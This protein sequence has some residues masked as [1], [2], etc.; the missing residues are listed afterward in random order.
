MPTPATTPPRSPRAREPAGGFAARALHWADGCGRRRQVRGARRLRAPGGA[1]ALHATRSCTSCWARPRSPTALAE[2]WGPDAAPGGD[3][4]RDRVGP[5]RLRPA[6]RSCGWLESVLH[7]LVGERIGRVARGAARRLARWPWSRCRC[8]SRPGWRAPS[9]RPS[10]SP[11]AD[12]VRV[13]RAGARGTEQ[14]DGRSA[15]Q[16]SQ[17]E[18]AARATHV[19]RQ[20]TAPRRAARGGASR[21][22]IADA[23]PT[24]EGLDE[25]PACPGRCCWPVGLGAVI[26]FAISRIDVRRGDPRGDAPAAPRRHHPPAGGARRPRSGADRRR[27]STR[28]RASA[29]RPP[30][31]GPA[32]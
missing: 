26:A 31:P 17:D 20:T 7:P 9:M 15:R 25:G 11:R 22:L 21:Q 30:A 6:R 14:L 13:E 18:K 19:A 12:E 32:A 10:R 4:D 5:D 8:C 24:A 1:D 29:T 16:L 27:S 3:V 2:R 28:S 23:R